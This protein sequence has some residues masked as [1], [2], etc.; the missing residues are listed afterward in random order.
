LNQQP[1]ILI[2][3]AQDKELFPAFLGLSSMDS[4]NKHARELHIIALNK[5]VGVLETWLCTFA[6]M[7][8]YTPDVPIFHMNFNMN[9]F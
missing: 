6:D 2:N 3:K 4:G 7:L 8:F 5:K 1:S 9:L